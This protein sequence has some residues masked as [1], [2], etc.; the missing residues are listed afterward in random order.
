MDDQILIYIEQFP[1][2]YLIAIRKGHR[3]HTAMLNNYFRRLKKALHQEKYA[4]AT[5]TDRSKAFDCLD[6]DLLLAELK[7]YGFDECS[8]K[9]I[10]S[11]LDH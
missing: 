1:S 9:F 6:Y 10:Q 7:A 2:P 11:Y 5:L 8:L 4:G 3:T